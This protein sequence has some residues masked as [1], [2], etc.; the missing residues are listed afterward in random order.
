MTF[1]GSHNRRK[2]QLRR[3]KNW[4]LGYFFV[5]RGHFLI[6]FRRSISRVFALSCH[7]VGAYVESLDYTSA[8]TTGQKSTECDRK[9]TNIDTKS[10]GCDNSVSFRDTF[11]SLRA[12]HEFRVTSNR[13]RFFDFSEFAWVVRF[14]ERNIASAFNSWR[15][16]GVSPLIQPPSYTVSIDRYY[17]ANA[18]VLQFCNFRSIWVARRLR[19]LSPCQNSRNRYSFARGGCASVKT[20]NLCLRAAQLRR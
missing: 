8:E 17:P 1:F 4:F 9:S 11:A 16:V 13:L 6:G 14:G 15:A 20:T 3:P 5:S 12:R 10:T 19:L 18:V 7:P 2:S